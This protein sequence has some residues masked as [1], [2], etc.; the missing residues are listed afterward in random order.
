ML[1]LYTWNISQ[2]P[3]GQFE[4]RLAELP[5]ALHPTITRFVR[6]QDRQASLYGK[7]LLI[8]GLQQLGYGKAKMNELIYN[9]WKRPTFPGTLDFNISHSGQ[10]VACILRPDGR[11]GVDVEQ[12]KPIRVHDYRSVLTPREKAELEALPRPED[13][14]FEMWT[15]KEAVIKAE[16][17]GFYN[18]LDNVEALGLDVIRLE[19]ED[20]HVK[21]IPIDPGYVCH[22][23]S[24]IF[25]HEIRIEK[26]LV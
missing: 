24:D 11:I 17:K 3:A 1:L 2:L 5:G 22:L 6:W 16:G 7:L 14:F 20:W 9:D 13:R 21:E 26:R 4:E 15:K 19:K 23:A 18:R 25:I 12:K 8:Q 10:L